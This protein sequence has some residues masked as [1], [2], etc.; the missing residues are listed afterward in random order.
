MFTIML[1]S[2]SLSLSLDFTCY[3][4]F[5]LWKPHQVSM[6]FRE[7]AI[8]FC[9]SS[10]LN[11]PMVPFLSLFYRKIMILSLLSFQEWRLYGCPWLLL[12]KSHVR[13]ET[14]NKERGGFREEEMYNIVSPLDPLLELLLL[15]VDL[16][17]PEYLLILSLVVSMSSAKPYYIHFVSL[18]LLFCFNEEP[19]LL[20]C[21]CDLSSTSFPCIS[22]IDHN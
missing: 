20:Y 18:L 6:E 4:F 19:F 7:R 10:L 16:F 21:S 3:L 22:F 8:S 11:E 12:L 17:F 14:N 13:W 5:V 1:C 2:L 15:S 9:C